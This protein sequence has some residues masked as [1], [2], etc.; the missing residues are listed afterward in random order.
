[1]IL[2]TKGESP[3][4]GG[5]SESEIQANTTTTPESRFPVD[6]KEDTPPTYDSI[7]PIPSASTSPS[8]PEG[9]NPTNYVTI[10]R[11]HEAIKADFVIDPS[12]RIPDALLPPLPSG[13]NDRNNLHLESYHGSIKTEVHV[14]PPSRPPPS[15]QP[16][17]TTL[18]MKTE[19]G[20]ILAKLHVATGIR[21]PIHLSAINKH[22]SIK[23]YIPRSF[24]GLVSVTKGNGCVKFSDNLQKK[25]TAFG[26]AKQTQKYFVGNLAEWSNIEGEW[27]GDEIGVENKHG[28]VKI[29]Y[30][31]DVT[32]SKVVQKHS[33]FSKWSS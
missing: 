8:S 12:L 21:P 2:P 11:K 28:A 26:E 6:N 18:M 17:R 16:R 19:H 7:R 29:H 14:M 3:L 33:F 23:I 20:A 30:T 32:D 4:E 9:L 13:Q 25:L 27:D 5:T 24:V 22:G 15:D 1:M 31:E 10:M